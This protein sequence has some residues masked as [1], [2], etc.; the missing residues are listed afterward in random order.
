MADHLWKSLLTEFLG[1]FTLVF[2]GA[3]TVALT[4]QQGGSLLSSALAFGLT[5]MIIIYV[6]GS[7]SGAHVN[8]AVSLG[9]AISGQMNWGLMLGYWIAQILGGIAA[10]ALVAYFFGTANGAGA[11]IGE[12]TRTDAWKAVLMEAILTFTLVIAY[13]FIYRDPLKAL[14]AGAAIGLVL[15][16]AML[17]GGWATGASMNPARSLGSALFTGN[18]GTYWIY[19]IGPLIGALLAALVYKLYT[20]KFNCI[21]VLSDCGEEVKDDYGNVLKKC[22]RTMVDKCGNVLKADCGKNLTEIY[23]ENDHK[24][25][26]M[27]ATL[28]SSAGEWME[29]GGINPSYAKQEFIHAVDKMM[30]METQKIPVTVTTGSVEQIM[31]YPKRYVTV[32]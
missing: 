27:Q 4:V 15:T 22:E 3:S 19:I 29:S 6:W 14:I 5:L 25:S 30:P 7:Y 12:F 9:F 10:A 28:K 26:Y 16:I 8:P 31:S 23:Y 20:Y 17:A 18:L 1:T 13:L 32:S 11:S 2:I 24:P 21:S